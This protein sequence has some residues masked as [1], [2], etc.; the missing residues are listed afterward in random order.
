MGIEELL[1]FLAAGCLSAVYGV[2]GA[3]KLRSPD[4]SARSARELGVA[5]P[6]ASARLIRVLARFEL[7]LSAGFLLVQGPVLTAFSA[8]SAI[9]LSAFAWLLARAVHRGVQAPCP[10]F[11]SGGSVVSLWDVTR[12]VA[13]VVMSAGAGSAGLGGHGLLASLRSATLSDGVWMLC[14]AAVILGSVASTRDRERPRL[15]PRL[16]GRPVPDVELV[17]VTGHVRTLPQLVG[18]RPALVVFTK[19][20]CGA[21]EVAAVR[22]AA[23]AGRLQGVTVMVATSA[24]TSELTVPEGGALHMLGAAAARA[25]FGVGP[26]PAAV[27]LSHDGAVASELVE[28]LASIEEFVDAIE[29]LL[30]AAH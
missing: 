26:M 3:L 27:L 11:G 4:S 30:P 13:L 8:V 16:T 15:S 5:P 21:C 12:D 28:G 25:A 20:G 10:C 19:A 29:G 18:G 17:A 24:D 2:S 22:A 7:I 23:W 9:V 6:F 14:V 1:A